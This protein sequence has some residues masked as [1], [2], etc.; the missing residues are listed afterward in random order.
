MELLKMIWPGL[1]RGWT[2]PA[3]RNPSFTKRGP[4]RK[5]QQF[6]KVKP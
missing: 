3:Q 1:G 2:F 5:H 4:G 6:K